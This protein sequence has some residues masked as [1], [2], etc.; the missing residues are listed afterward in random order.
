[1]IRDAEMF[2]PKPHTIDATAVINKKRQLFFSLATV[3][4]ERPGRGKFSQLVTDHF[5][6]DKHFNV[7]F[8]V[9]NQKSV[10]DKLRH[11]RASPGP[12]LDRLFFIL[13]I[14][15]LNFDE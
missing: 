3:A 10:A 7:D 6:R 13:G 14:Q 4:A 2:Y 12:R 9:M 15:F 1:M 5:F 8:A 11:D